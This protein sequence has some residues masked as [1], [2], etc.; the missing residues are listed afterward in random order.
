MGVK[1]K[2]EAKTH[3]F[4]TELKKFRQTLKAYD[5][6]PVKLYR[7]NYIVITP[8]QLEYYLKTRE[9]KRTDPN[10]CKE[11]ELV[12]KCDHHICLKAVRERRT[13]ENN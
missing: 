9:E 1:S 3:I 5:R 13:D 4:L 7:D 12:D 2:L 8:D 10:N 11:C 6:E